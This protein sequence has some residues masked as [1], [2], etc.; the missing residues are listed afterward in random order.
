MVELSV[1]V[2]LASHQDIHKATTADSNS[3]RISVLYEYAIA[4][5]VSSNSVP[6]FCGIFGVYA[7]GYFLKMPH[8]TDMPK[9]SLLA[10]KQTAFTCFSAPTFNS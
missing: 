3:L 1:S 8:K 9:S 2:E 4:T 7:V 5:V 10:L 6:Y